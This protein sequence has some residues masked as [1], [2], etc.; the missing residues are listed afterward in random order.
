M[1][2]CDPWPLNP[3]GELL[4]GVKLEKPEGHRHGRRDLRRPGLG[5]AADGARR[6]SL[7]L[8]S[9]KP[10]AGPVSANDAGGAR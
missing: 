1:N 4:L 9:V 8:G 7:S 6:S 5:F 3:N 10:A 2:R